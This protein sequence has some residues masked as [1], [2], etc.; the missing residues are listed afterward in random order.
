M[1]TGHSI[2]SQLAFSDIPTPSFSMPQVAVRFAS[3]ERILF[4]KCQREDR[5]VVL[6]ATSVLQ[7]GGLF[8]WATCTKRQGN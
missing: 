1:L 3:L 7:Y 8:S 2:Y 5:F 6:E 4:N